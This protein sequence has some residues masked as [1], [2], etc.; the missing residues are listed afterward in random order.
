MTLSLTRCSVPEGELGRY[1]I[2]FHLCGNVKGSVVARNSIRASNQRCVVV[3]G[4][5]N[6]TIA[7]NVAF[8]TKGHCFMTEDGGEV[9]NI[10]DRNLG[11]KTEPATRLVRPFETDGSNPSTFWVSPRTRPLA[12]CCRTTLI[13]VFALLDVQSVQHVDGKRCSGI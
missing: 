5:H 10:F 1:P 11:A 8:D 2:H 12:S 13:R 3:H 9:D 6:V 4:S 7:A